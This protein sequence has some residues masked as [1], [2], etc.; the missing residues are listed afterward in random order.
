MKRIFRWLAQIALALF[1]ILTIGTIGLLLFAR[2]QARDTMIPERRLATETPAD[3]GIMIWEDITY[4]TP[5]GLTLNAYFIPPD[6]STN[7]ATLIYVHG[8]TGNR[9]SFLP[10]AQTTIE[11]GYGALLVAL[12]AHD[13]SEGDVTTL[14]VNEVNDIEGAITYLQSR[15]DVNAEHLGIVG[16]SLGCMVAIPAAAQLPEIDVLIGQ[17]CM[18]DFRQNM[19]NAIREIVGLPPFPFAPLIAFFGQ[20]TAKV[21]IDEVKPINHIDDIAPRPVLLI[22]GDVDT[23]FPVQNSYDLFEEAAEPKQLHILNGIGH[24][25]FYEEAGDEIDAQIVPFLETYLPNR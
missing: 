16:Q 5:D 11:M 12:R 19:D 15:T 14:G 3:Y 22:H 25:P 18:A 1:F 23:L 2:Q 7:G 24:W 4:E 8:L 9:Q 13:T 20:R 21:D 17:S 10:Q 6:P